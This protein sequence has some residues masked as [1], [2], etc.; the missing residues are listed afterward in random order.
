MLNNSH[1][2]REQLYS[3]QKQQFGL[4]AVF[5][6]LLLRHYEVHFL[7]VATW[8][9]AHSISFYAISHF[10]T[11]IVLVVDFSFDK[12]TPHRSSTSADCWAASLTSILYGAA[13]IISTLLTFLL[14]P[15][16]PYFFLLW[17]FMHTQVWMLRAFPLTPTIILWKFASQPASVG[18]ISISFCVSGVIRQDL[19]GGHFPLENVTVAFW[20]CLAAE[21]SSSS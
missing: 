10:V 19:S 21:S 4:A 5:V 2:C 13:V 14:S 8:K 7:P 17:W 18:Y 6:Q 12:N 11:W 3:Y 20:E 15:S 16:R 1:S 9:C